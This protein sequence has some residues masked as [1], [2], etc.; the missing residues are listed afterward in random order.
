M[1]TVSPAAESRPLAPLLILAR[2]E[3]V[4]RLN[5]I[6]HGGREHVPSLGLHRI[7]PNVCR[8]VRDRAIIHVTAS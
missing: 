4:P 3:R 2:S 1:K 8:R 5:N 6:E 7:D